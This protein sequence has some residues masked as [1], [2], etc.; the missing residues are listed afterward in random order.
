[1]TTLAVRAGAS[2]SYLKFTVPALSGAIQ[3]ARL[4]V[5]VTN[6]STSAGT[7]YLSSSSWTESGITWNNAPAATSGAIATVGTATVGTWVEFDV[8]LVVTSSTT[9][10]FLL[11][12]GDNDAVNYSSRTGANPPQLVIVSGP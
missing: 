6:A 7:A 11:S 10:T 9:M 3:S 8:T 1:M 12:D 4:R 5:F 2:R